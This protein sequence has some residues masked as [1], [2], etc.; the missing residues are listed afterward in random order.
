MYAKRN[1]RFR[2]FQFNRI[3]VIKTEINYASGGCRCLFITLSELA[4]PRKW[5][6]FLY[7]TR[8]QRRFA[9]NNFLYLVSFSL[10]YC[11]LILPRAFVHFYYGYKQRFVSSLRVDGWM[12]GF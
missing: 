12:D 9:M 8:N 3:H 10:K 2:N 7:V 4:T 11:S 6:L 5:E 1:S